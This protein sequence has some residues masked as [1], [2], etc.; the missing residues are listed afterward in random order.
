MGSD[1]RRRQ[2]NNKCNNLVL[3]FSYYRQLFI[4]VNHLGTFL[5]PQDY[6]VATYCPVDDCDTITTRK[7]F[8][9]NARFNLTRRDRTYGLRQNVDQLNQNIT[10]YL[11]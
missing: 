9:M 7:I 6:E 2:S 5:R 1:I 4:S 3:Y 10:T 8:V 11:E